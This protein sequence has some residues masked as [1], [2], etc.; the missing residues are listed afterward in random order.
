MPTRD[1]VDALTA[2]MTTD[3]ADRMSAFLAALWQ[4]GGSTLASFPAP[5]RDVGHLDETAL[6]YLLESED[7]TDAAFWNRVVR[8]ISLPILLRTPA[9]GTGNLPVLDA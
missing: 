7:I 6:M 8:M 4:G 1:A 5:Q 3:V 9:A 2:R